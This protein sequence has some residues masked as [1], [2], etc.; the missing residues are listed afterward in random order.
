MDKYF[1]A[2]KPGSTPKYKEYAAIAQSRPFNDTELH[3]Q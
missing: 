2:K 3:R 1:L